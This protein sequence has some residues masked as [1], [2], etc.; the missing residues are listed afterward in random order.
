[1]GESLQTVERALLVIEALAQ[2]EAGLSAL[3][4]S[5]GMPKAVVYRIL[6][7]LAN[8]GYVV[9]DPERVVYRLG[10]RMFEMGSSVVNRTG[11]RK[12]AVGPMGTL[13]ILTRETVNLAI[14]DGVDV[15]YIDRI[16][17]AE[18]LRADLQVGSRV[19][20]H[21][22]ALGKAILA[23][24]PAGEAEIILKGLLFQPYTSRTI[25]DET[26]LRLE[27]EKTRR[28]GYSLD[29]EEYVE[30]IRCMGA[31][32]RDHA[33]RVVAAVSVDGPS[34]RITHSRI[35]ELAGPLKKTAR[36]IS[37]SLMY[38]DE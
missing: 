3:S 27:L 7:T 10:V 24:L 13:A 36:D 17:C 4:R 38:L 37:R 14:P 1:M 32:I 20:M 5:L 16:E 34:V 31:P 12:A 21:C 6:T 35:D 33:G 15:L 25:T 9:Q 28:T 23:F 19:P 2:K 22:S 18:P 26:A 29:D 30:G 11:L 8:R